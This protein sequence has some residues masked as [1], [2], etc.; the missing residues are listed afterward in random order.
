MKKKTVEAAQ[1]IGGP[2][3]VYVTSTEARAQLLCTGISLRDM[4]IT[5]RDRNPYL[6]PGQEHEETPV[7]MF[8]T[9]L[10]PMTTTPSL[11]I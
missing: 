7:F 11:C 10:C 2:W 3:R 1:R 8:V 4:Q 9:S 6:L 5:L